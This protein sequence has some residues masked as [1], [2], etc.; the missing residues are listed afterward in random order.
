MRTSRAQRRAFWVVAKQENGRMGMLTI[1]PGSD[2]ETL[3]VFSYR[4]E[5]EAFLRLGEVSETDWW[6]RETT[7][8]ELVSMLYGP[9][10][11]VKRV[12]L[13]PLPAAVGGVTLVDLVSLD[14]ERF[15]GSLISERTRACGSPPRPALGVGT[16]RL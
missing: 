6:I 10:A 11:A 1:D 13:D 8:G 4:E 15:V 3:P 16:S 7:A 12:A 5:A 14:R 2:R 9:C